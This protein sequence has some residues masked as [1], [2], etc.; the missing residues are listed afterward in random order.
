MKQYFEKQLENSKPATL[1]QIEETILDAKDAQFATEE[2]KEH[3]RSKGGRTLLFYALRVI[4]EG[5][6]ALSIEKVW[7]D[8]VDTLSSDWVFESCTD[9][10]IPTFHTAEYKL[11]KDDISL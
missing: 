8:E 9:S 4:R 10:G 3:R 2:W 6:G 5:K 11:T 1:E 7:D